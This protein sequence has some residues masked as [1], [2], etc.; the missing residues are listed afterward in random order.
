M[1][2][3]ISLELV[4]H[5]AELARLDLAD[6][7]LATYTSQLDAIVGYV[8]QLDRLDLDAVEGTAHAV[9]LTCPWREDEVQPSIGREQVLEPA[10]DQDG[11]HFVVPRIIE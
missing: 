8:A 5:V 3:A 1:D 11:E 9:D 10:P 6:E 4:R 2:N 7:E